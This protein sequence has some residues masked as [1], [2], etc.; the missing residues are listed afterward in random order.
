MV[1]SEIIE[2][3]SPTTPLLEIE[4]RFQLFHVPFQRFDYV[5]LLA[6]NYEIAVPHALANLSFWIE[7]ERTPELKQELTRLKTDIEPITPILRDIAGMPQDLKPSQRIK[8][9][10]VM[11]ML[12]EEAQRFVTEKDH[13][14][15][16][17][18]GYVNDLKDSRQELISEAVDLMRES[19]TADSTSRADG[20]KRCHRIFEDYVGSD[21]GA[22]DGVG[23]MYT[24]WLQWK[25]TRDIGA[26][27]NG[28][29]TSVLNGQD[30]PAN[31]RAIS[32]VQLSLIQAMHELYDGALQNM[33]KALD[34]QPS[35]ENALVAACFAN[36][37]ARRNATENYF[38]IAIKAQPLSVISFFAFPQ[39]F[40]GRTH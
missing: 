13:Y 23:W 36:V 5:K 20:L 21:F 39:A 16:F 28:F 31:V 33:A 25:L 38:K 26:A 4:W 27:S 10:M 8:H 24:A 32:Q 14:V 19:M 30:L 15:R 9:Q 34:D 22:N 6:S 12:E 11:D 37:A 35:S 40:E 3:P 29:F 2:R 18:N 1:L 7:Q 17:I